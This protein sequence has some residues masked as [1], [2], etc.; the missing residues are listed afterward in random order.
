MKLKDTSSFLAEDLRAFILAGCKHMGVP[1]N[2]LVVETGDGW[3][4]KWRPSRGRYG[5]RLRPA[6]WMRIIVKHHLRG[7]DPGS[8]VDPRERWLAMHPGRPVEGDVPAD[9]VIARGMAH[10]IEHECL[11]LL[12]VLHRDMTLEQRFFAKAEEA[13]KTYE[14]ARGLGIRQ[15][16]VAAALPP[17]ARL[18]L[19]RAERAKKS[20]RS[21]ERAREA[22][23]RWE[24]RL[25]TVERRV[26]K[27]RARVRYYDRKAAA[28][29]TR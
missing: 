2:G 20:A 24:A 13:G 16:P 17:V 4:G 11:H 28:G 29:G 8:G 22:L 12:G 19:A 23:A 10:V 25:V 5:S 21:E 6:R 1:T 26:R 27:L 15:K 7:E 14:W 18:E 9:S 3:R